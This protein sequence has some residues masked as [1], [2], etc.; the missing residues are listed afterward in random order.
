LSEENALKL[1][2]TTWHNIIPEVHYSES[3]SLHEN[4]TKIKAQAHSDYINAI[5]NTY[6]VDVDIMVEAKQKD[7]AIIKFI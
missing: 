5:P 7:L 2:A 1:A 4:N 6:D 3:K